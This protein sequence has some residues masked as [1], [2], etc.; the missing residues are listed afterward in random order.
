MFDMVSGKYSGWMSSEAV[1]ALVSHDEVSNISPAGGASVIQIVEVCNSFLLEL[2][3]YKR[4][5]VPHHPL[6]C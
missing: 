2:R 4:P 1:S 3:T 6:V 5:G